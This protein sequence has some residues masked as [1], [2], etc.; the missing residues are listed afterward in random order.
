MHRSDLELFD[1]STDL[2][3]SAVDPTVIGDVELVCPEHFVSL[4]EVAG[5]EQPKSVGAA[6]NFDTG[7]GD[8]HLCVQV[9][10]KLPG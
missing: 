5:S 10:L 3:A 9:R 6:A 7:W 1:R 8:D 4:C 2:Y